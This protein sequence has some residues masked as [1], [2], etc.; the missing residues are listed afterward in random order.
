[1][2]LGVTCPAVYPD[3]SQRSVPTVPASHYETESGKSRQSPSQAAEW[4]SAM[5]AQGPIGV[6][7]CLVLVVGGPRREI[8]RRDA[9]LHYSVLEMVRP[10][11][12]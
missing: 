11:P 12:V 1:M 10:R 4:P 2:H 5:P 8:P 3:D 9:Q 6:C 7:R